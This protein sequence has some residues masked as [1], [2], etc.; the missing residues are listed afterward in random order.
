VYLKNK[1]LFK[2]Y[3]VYCANNEEALELCEKLTDN[4]KSKFYALHERVRSLPQARGLSLVDYLIMPV[5]RL[6]KYPLLFRELLKNTPETHPEFEQ[7]QLVHQEMHQVA[8]FVNEHNRKVTNIRKVAS[9]QQSLSGLGKTRLATQHRRF[10]REGV[11][12]LHDPSSIRMVFLFNDLLVITKGVLLKKNKYQVKHVFFLDEFVQ[13]YDREDSEVFKYSFELID[14]NGTTPAVYT[15][16]APSLGEKTAWFTAIANVFADNGCEMPQL[17]V[18]R[19]KVR[20]ASTKFSLE[21]L[22]HDLLAKKSAGAGPTSL[23]AGHESRASLDHSRLSGGALEA[24]FSA[25]Q[26][27][28]SPPSA[29]NATRN[30][31]SLRRTSH[32]SGSRIDLLQQLLDA[33]QE[34]VSGLRAE[35]EDLA[36]LH[37]VLHEELSTVRQAYGAATIDPIFEKLHLDSTLFAYEE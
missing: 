30:W 24:S 14:A 37:A 16:M 5:Q 25:G 9:I 15:L 19:K 35:I 6:C 13:L 22:H 10:V 34:R 27:T 7:I 29:R 32:A 17:G 11:L 36:Q 2:I 21:D 4:K 33:K 18:Y 1:D 31:A 20:P 28:T 26:G 23:A 3:G 8:A 12:A